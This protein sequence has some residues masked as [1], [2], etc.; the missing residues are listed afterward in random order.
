MKHRAKNSSKKAQQKEI[1]QSNEL[2]DGLTAE[3]TKPV[4]LFQ[5]LLHNRRAMFMIGGA[6]VGILLAGILTVVYAIDDGSETE[7]PANS[8]TDSESKDDQEQSNIN[9]DSKQ[10]LEKAI[11]ELKTIETED[12]STLDPL[13]IYS[14]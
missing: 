14:E 11:D 6:V 10:D 1:K 13:N 9:I 12:T 4:S 7:T 3:E 2:L 5:K 8:L